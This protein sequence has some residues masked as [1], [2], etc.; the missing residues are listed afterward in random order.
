M[1][2]KVYEGVYWV[3][4]VTL[5]LALFAAPVFAPY[6]TQPRERAEKEVLTVNNDAE[7]KEEIVYIHLEEKGP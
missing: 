1:K 4:G 7:T 6:L 5:L 3:L 2:Q